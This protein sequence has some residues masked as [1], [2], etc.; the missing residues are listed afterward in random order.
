LKTGSSLQ[1]A[2]P[3][4]EDRASRSAVIVRRQSSELKD[5]V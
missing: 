3:Q 5:L 4:F 2:I 1:R